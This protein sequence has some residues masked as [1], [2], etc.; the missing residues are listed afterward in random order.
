MNTFLPVL[1]SSAAIGALVSSALT[2]YGQHVERNSRRREMLLAQSV[3]LAL[4]HKENLIKLAQL[5]NESVFIPPEAKLVQT[6][7]I[8]L[9]EL[10]TERRLPRGM[11]ATDSREDQDAF[12]RKYGA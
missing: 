11:F 3:T 8:A 7:F 2:L 5:Q 4:S 10:I 1:L 12:Q 6:Y 9:S